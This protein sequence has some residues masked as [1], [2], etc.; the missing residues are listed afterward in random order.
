MISL[1]DEGSEEPARGKQQHWYQKPNLH[2]K[3]VAKMRV[4]F[5]V[6][7]LAMPLPAIMPAPG[8]VVPGSVAP[9]SAV[10][11]NAAH[12]IIALGDVA[13][14]RSPP[15]RSWSSPASPAVA[16]ITSCAAHTERRKNYVQ[17]RQ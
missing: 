13:L 5:I 11:G 2:R 4:V 6:L 15:L 16:A 12:C 3:E 1:L 7:L 17:A 9:G 14:A 8:S 10:P